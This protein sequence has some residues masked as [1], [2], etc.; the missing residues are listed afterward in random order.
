[1]T[2]DRFDRFDSYIVD[3]PVDCVS[4]GA[5]RPCTDAVY[6]EMQDHYYCDKDCFVD[7]AGMYSG[8]VDGY[9]YEMNCGG[10]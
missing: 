7:W 1:M 9:Y 5:S 6:D 8:L 3:E 2:S 4:C 10:D